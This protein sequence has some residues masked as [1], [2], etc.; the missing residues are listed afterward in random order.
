MHSCCCSERSIEASS[1]TRPRLLPQS[2]KRIGFFLIVLIGWCLGIAAAC[3]QEPAPDTNARETI[4]VQLKWRHQF[5]FAGYYAAIEKGYFREA[6]LEVELLPGQPDRNPSD[7][8]SSGQAEF[9]V[10]SPAVLLE[11][12]QGRPLVV[13][14]AIFQHSA[15]V[16]MT[17]KDAGLVTPQDLKGKRVMMTPESDPENLAMLKHAGISPDSLTILPHNWSVEDLIAGRVDGQS[18]YLSNEPYLMKKRGVAPAFIQ[19]V[20]WGI[21]FYGDCLVG[22][23]HEMSE[24]PKRTE[25]FRR[26]VQ[27]GWLYAMEH[28]EEI[29]RLILARY[30]Q[31]KSLEHLLFEA[32]AMRA[33]IRP[34]LV[35]IG[36]L[37]PERWRHIAD[38][39]VQLGMLSPGY[40]LKGLLYSQVQEDLAAS[41]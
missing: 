23:E 27:R 16:I 8:L 34:E 14:A 30:S 35:E 28:P 24:H 17:R 37:N 4:R 15:N 13:L 33:L 38:T 18:A 31:E 3:A 6:G 25:A 40:S 7:A 32:E 22:T 10:L 11:R 20:H 39:Y 2:L 41:R 12:Q 26:A 21:D 9:A 29:A 1:H 36:H 5:Q 19:P